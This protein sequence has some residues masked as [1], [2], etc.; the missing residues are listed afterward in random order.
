MFHPIGH[1][2]HSIAAGMYFDVAHAA[3]TD[4]PLTDVKSLRK[5]TQASKHVVIDGTRFV[6]VA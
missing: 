2:F 5:H 6:S 4:L 3:Q 1:P